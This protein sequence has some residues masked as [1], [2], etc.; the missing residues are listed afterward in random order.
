MD[1]D[2]VFPPAPTVMVALP[3]ETPLTKPVLLTVATLLELE[4]VKLIPA[5]G[6]PF[7]SFAAGCNCSTPPTAI[8]AAVGET[9]IVAKLGDT[10][11]SVE[12]PAPP[13]HPAQA[14]TVIR[15]NKSRSEEIKAAGLN[16]REISR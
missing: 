5:I 14:I 1:T 8:F 11:G 16:V 9:A 13:P 12:L 7:S 10:K 6:L 2:A 15:T 3:A 4:K